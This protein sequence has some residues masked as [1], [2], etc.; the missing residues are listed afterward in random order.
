M[1][2]LCVGI[3]ILL[4]LSVFQLI[5]AG[6]VPATS[7]AVP[8]V[9]KNM[10]C[11]SSSSWSSSSFAHLALDYKLNRR[12]KRQTQFTA[13]LEKLSSIEDRGQTDRV[14]ALTRP[15]ALD[16]AAAA[17]MAFPQ[18]LSYCRLG[19]NNRKDIWPIKTCDTYAKSSQQQ[20][21]SYCRPGYASEIDVTLK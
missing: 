12:L 10:H 8:L 14:T 2:L 11:T 15:H 20:L 13:P 16:S 18:V 4:S 17:V 9:G 3:T 7:L 1:C 19:K 21:S 6:M 5:V